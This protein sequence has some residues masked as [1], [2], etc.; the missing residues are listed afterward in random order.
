MM[1]IQNARV[2]G[3]GLVRLADLCVE[4]GRIVAIGES[5]KLKG[6]TCINA[7][8]LYLSHG[9]IDIHVHGGGGHD[10]MDGTEEAWR[11]AAALHLRHG[12]TALVPTAMA[13]TPK[14]LA[15][16]L[17][18]YARWQQGFPDGARF[19]GLHL[20]GP[21]IAP[22]QAGAQNPAFLHA[23]D[24][25]EYTALLQRTSDIA[26][27]TIAPELPG[28]LELGDALLQAGVLPC[29]GHSD[30]TFSQVCAALSHGYRHITHLYSACSTI[31]RQKGIRQAGIV[32]SAYLLDSL[33]SEIIADGC[34]LP[35]ALLK[36]AYRHIGPDRLC[37]V[38]DAMRAAGQT[39]GESILG[40]L[41]EGQRVILEDGVAKMPD[42]EA[43][44]GS[45]A[46][47]DTL[48]RN[49]VLLAG[50]TLPDAVKMMTETPARIL[51]LLG[52]T[53]LILPGRTADLVLF[54]EDIGIQLVLI[55]GIV[56]VNNGVQ[57]KQ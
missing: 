34:H 27:W 54:D 56:R 52:Q 37:L 3:N 40:S 11:G 10:F 1:I 6:G 53:G 9:F 30:A 39:T 41:Q 4:N 43:L 32:E 7:K 47:A 5:G 12:T 13:A 48:V 50:A 51:G 44:A 57:V 29:I 49:M 33:T 26:R 31:V 23:P 24:A 22:Q 35:P 2:V 20:E 8:G 15:D 28:A 38:T 45:I 55:D 42:R 17:A 25:G 19:L 46:T 21:Y 18:A 36:M 16:T 14:A